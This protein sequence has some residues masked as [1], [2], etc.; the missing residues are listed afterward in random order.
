MF[1]RE[2]SQPYLTDACIISN[3]TS[4]IGEIFSKKDFRLDG[5]FRGKLIC[6]KRVILGKKA[7]FKGELN[8][9]NLSIYGNIEAQ[10]TVSNEISINSTAIFKGN[11]ITH[12]LKVEEGAVF[13]GNCSTNFQDT[14]SESSTKK[15]SINIL[16]SGPVESS[17][18]SEI[19]TDK[20]STNTLE[21]EETDVTT[22]ENE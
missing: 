1:N 8:C 12:K 11:L 21:K 22:V 7:V 5:V 2:T 20:I 16:S 3:K 15:D 10:V 4:I 14:V 9:E 18:E 13:E 17:I 19:Q 6:K